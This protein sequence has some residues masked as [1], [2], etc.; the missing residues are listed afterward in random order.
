MLCGSISFTVTFVNSRQC[1]VALARF[2]EWL[3]SQLC[4]VARNTKNER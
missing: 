2:R 4:G 1:F 3:L